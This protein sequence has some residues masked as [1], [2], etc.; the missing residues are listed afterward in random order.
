MT[1]VE[2]GLSPCQPL[3][4]VTGRRVGVAWRGKVNCVE[5]EGV[6][7]LGTAGSWEMTAGVN[8]SELGDR[9]G[10]CQRGVSAHKS[11]P[12]VQPYERGE[13]LGDDAVGFEAMRDRLRDRSRNVKVSL[14]PFIVL[15][16]NCA[17]LTLHADSRLSIRIRD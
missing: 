14:L 6:A 15:T 12:Y 17:V 8:L 3:P 1:V 7:R 13:A 5:R 2:A 11:S 9:W 10:R 4:A 16:S